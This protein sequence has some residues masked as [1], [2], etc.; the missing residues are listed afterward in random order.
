MR[1]SHD[2]KGY[3]F[4]NL[5]ITSWHSYISFCHQHFPVFQEERYYMSLMHTTSH[6]LLS[7]PVLSCTVPSAI[8]FL[9]S[10]LGDAPRKDEVGETTGRTEG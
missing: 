3:F 4:G 9:L 10:H 2:P 8:D 7:H 5:N 1:G 6:S